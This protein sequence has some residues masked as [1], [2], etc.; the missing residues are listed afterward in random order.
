MAS[1]IKEKKKKYL[2]AVILLIGVIFSTAIFTFWN[3]QK[4]KSLREETLLAREIDA[5]S[6]QTIKLLTDIETGTRGKALTGQ[7]KYLEPYVTAKAM[8][9]DNLSR[10][11]L[12]MTTDATELIQVKELI[13][14][15][16]AKVAES[17]IIIPLSGQSAISR[18]QSGEE[19]R[20]M[21]RARSL[22]GSIRQREQSKVRMLVDKGKRSVDLSAFLSFVLLSSSSCLLALVGFF[23]LFEI[24]SQ[25]V[26]NKQLAD[27]L[28]FN[29]HVMGQV[30]H[31]VRLPIS[32]IKNCLFILKENSVIKD[33]SL[34]HFWDIADS[35]VEQANALLHGIMLKV[36]SQL[37]A[38][39]FLP[40][41]VDAVHLCWELIDMV[42]ATASISGSI[43]CLVERRV[44]G[45]PREVSL[46]ESLLRQILPNLLSNAIKFSPGAEPIKVELIF[47]TQGKG[48]R[49]RVID[50]GI[51]IPQK[52]LDNMDQAFYR[53]GNASHIVGEGLGLLFV[54]DAVKA[55]RGR[56]KMKS[57]EGV[58][59]TFDV[60]LP[61]AVG[62]AS[63]ELPNSL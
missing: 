4:L 36:R 47:E 46:D 21:D 50:Q 28:N 10:L 45:T 37:G 1:A 35:A 26:L 34:L 53:G 54:Y 27:Q 57:R 52:K 14:V 9:E 6:G 5:L 56:I 33:E 32:T 40:K 20:L 61:D 59:T 38:L 48:I 62:A 51:G 2:A 23:S 41:P 16:N 31:D 25:K 44:I 15:A 18:I 3:T 49:L 58:G 12:L 42:Q 24:K 8:L 55:H 22:V 19:K 13:Q 29:R 7:Q 43:Y 60:W 63:F 17:E 11:K 39:V 30:S